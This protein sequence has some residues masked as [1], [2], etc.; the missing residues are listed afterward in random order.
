MTVRC[1]AGAVR[2]SNGGDTTDSPCRGTGPRV[3]VSRNGTV[4]AMVTLALIASGCL[5]SQTASLQLS[6]SE[7]PGDLFIYMTIEEGELARAEAWWSQN[8]SLMDVEF[9]RRVEAWE[10]V[11][12][13]NDVEL[14]R[15]PVLGSEDAAV[16]AWSSRDV[17]AVASTGDTFEVLIV[18]ASQGGTVASYGVEIAP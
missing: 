11:V 17:G 1:V 12:L 9:D 13:K 5:A 6:A 10:A 2:L 4:A 14:D 8:A 7:G 15:Q 16:F 3:G 18:N